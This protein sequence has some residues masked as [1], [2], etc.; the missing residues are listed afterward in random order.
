MELRG[1][2]YDAFISYRHTELDKFVAETLHKQLEN[3]RIPK[4]VLKDK[5]IA[6][7]PICIFRDQ[8]ELPLSSN[9]AESITEALMNSEYLIVICSPRLLESQWCQREIDTFIS[10][11][12]RSNV[13]TVLV[14]GEPHDSFPKQLLREDIEAVDENGN[15][16]IISR[17]LEPLAADVRGMNFKEVKKKIKIEK[18]RILAP[19]L[20]LNYDDLK[21]RHKEQQMKRAVSISAGI[22]TVLFGFCT[23]STIMALQIRRQAN[24]ISEQNKKITM[25]NE[26]ISLKS[27]EIIQ[28]SNL[29]QKQYE[30][31]QMNYSKSLADASERILADGDRMAA[32]YA[33]RKALPSNLTAPEI[34]YTAVSEYALTKAMYIYEDGDRFLPYNVYDSEA[35]I[36]FIDISEDGTKLLVVDA[37]SQVFIWD[38]QTN[39]LL[40]K[41]QCESLGIKDMAQFCGNNKLLYHSQA[42]LCEYNFDTRETICID[43]IADVAILFP[44]QSKY[45]ALSYNG[46]NCFDA[47]NHTLYFSNNELQVSMV[48]S[49]DVAFSEDGSKIILINHAME[50]EK[51]LILDAMTGEVIKERELEFEFA[52]LYYINGKA[53]VI[54]FQ[55][56]L[57]GGYYAHFC[58]IDTDTCEVLWENQHVDTWYLG[59]HCVQLDDREYLY[60]Y[61][62]SKVITMDVQTGELLASQ[63]TSQ[64][65]VGSS[66]LSNGKNELLICKDGTLINFDIVGGTAI[67]ISDLLNYADYTIRDFIWKPGQLY[68]LPQGNN[69]VL[70]YETQEGNQRSV[71]AKIESDESSGTM[72]ALG[73]LML[74]ETGSGD[75]RGLTLRRIQTKENISSVK[76]NGIYPEHC[77]IGDGSKEFAICKE[78]C[79][80]YSVEDGSILRTIKLSE[81]PEY[82]FWEYSFDGR[83]LHVN[84]Y[85][86]G[87]RI[88]SLETGELVLD[89]PSVKY[90]RSI[91][92]SDERSI[93]ACYNKDEYELYLYHWG[94]EMPFLVK[95]LNLTDTRAFFFS[96]DGKY[97]CVVTSNGDVCFYSSQTMELVKTIY[98]IDVWYVEGVEYIESINRYVIMLP[99][100]GYMLDEDLNLIADIPGYCGFNSTRKQ[101]IMNNGSEIS[102]IPYYAYQDLILAADSTL[103]RYEISEKVKREYNIE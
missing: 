36:S 10:T 83:L 17:E 50:H 62:S 41:V 1:K 89:L 38:T 59:G 93:Y 43:P 45:L 3:Y 90:R 12:G 85:T 28:Q 88:Y 79:T 98:D 13:F 40:L 22:A 27:N 37:M 91:I 65:I 55:G 72:N 26:D 61:N 25:Q 42:G 9:L 76:I 14:E 81:E 73:D 103:Q 100:I 39:K 15:T 4:Q 84:S 18:L 71:L 96:E 33:A 56:E 52:S 23:I 94:E 34:P 16:V 20:G 7:K 66:S 77:F 82:S 67:D 8:D 5:G 95:D 63:P 32:I 53:I 68:I 35:S 47:D 44:D 54:A 30:Q 102:C 57:I 46:I 87:D 75:K 99:Q 60:L 86:E 21:Q 24:H 70:K 19:M 58:C 78:D 92:F 6:R 74:I 69:R 80:V 48:T 51:F 101:L 64:G 31:V 11:H 49:S 97:F 29:I 2:K